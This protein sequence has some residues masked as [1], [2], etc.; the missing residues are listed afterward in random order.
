MN[1]HYQPLTRDDARALPDGALVCLGQTL[2]E[3]AKTA[4]KVADEYEA[5]YDVVKAEIARRGLWYQM[6]QS[7]DEIT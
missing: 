2:R 7:G 3:L 6:P 1:S 4:V 5:D